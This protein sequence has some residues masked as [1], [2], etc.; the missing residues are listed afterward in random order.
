MMQP[1][2][3]I[4]K[5]LNV[6]I[7]G[8][9]KGLGRALVKGFSKEGHNVLFTSRS[10]QNIHSTLDDVPLPLAASGRVVG[11][12]AD[13]A[14]TRDMDNL[15]IS[16]ERNFGYGLVDVWI[17]NA[18]LS[19]G[20][21]PF[22][23]TPVDRM[24]R[25]IDTNL[26]GTMAAS[27]RAVE[28]G[29]KKKRRLNHRI[30]GRKLHLFNVSGAGGDGSLTPEY[31]AYG[32]TKAA[33]VQFTR[34]LQREMAVDNGIGVHLISPGM[35]ATDLL[36]ENVCERKRAI[37]NI[38]CEEPDVVADALV[39]QICAVVGRGSTGE[40]LHFMTLSRVLLSLVKAPWTRDR[41]FR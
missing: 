22:V 4:H 14:N 39:P 16:I 32:A 5:P 29:E 27:Q 13:A 24:K 19:D 36:A 38:L 26:Y 28:I 31:A 11:L 30:G 33:I 34:T 3:M 10:P 2:H 17:N 25:I 40:F 6:V 18:A 8:G 12:V 20:N 35:M 37:Y 23:L 1:K 15:E 41:F 7:T 21:T 9:S